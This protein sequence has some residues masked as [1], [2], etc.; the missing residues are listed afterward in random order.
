M[1]A[2]SALLFVAANHEKARQEDQ[3]ILVK[4]LQQLLDND[5]NILDVL[6]VQREQILEALQDISNVGSHAQNS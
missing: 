6:E 5:T 1:E 4:T 3:V 2:T